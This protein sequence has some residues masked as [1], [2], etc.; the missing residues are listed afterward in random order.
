VLERSNTPPTCWTA[1]MRGWT[2]EKS[3]H[4]KFAENLF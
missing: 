2:S 4:A 3:Q 1:D